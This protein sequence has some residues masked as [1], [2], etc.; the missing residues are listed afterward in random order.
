[1][2]TIP[3]YHATIVPS[4]TGAMSTEYFENFLNTTMNSTSGELI[5]IMN[6]GKLVLSWREGITVLPPAP[7]QDLLFTVDASISTSLTADLDAAASYS[8]VVDWGDGSAD[9]ILSGTGNTSTSHTFTSTGVY[10]VKVSGSSVPRFR[11]RDQLNVV[12]LESLGNVGLQTTDTMFRDCTNLASVNI[13]NNVTSIGSQT[14]LG[15]TSLT[16]ITIPDSVTS[17]GNTTFNGCTSLTSIIIGNSVASIGIDVFDGTNLTY[18]SVDGVD[19]LFSDSYAF[20]IDGFSA[21]GNL[22][23]PSDVGGK[24]VRVI[25]GGAFKNCTSLTSVTIPDS[26]TS[27]GGYAFYNCT[28]LTSV[29]IP[30]S[31]TLIESSVFTLCQSLTSITIPN[32]VTSI[33]INA[34]NNCSSLTSA[35]IGNSVTSIGSYA[36]KNCTSLTSVT[37]PDSVTSIGSSAFAYCNSLLSIAIPDSVTSI[38]SLAFQVCAGLT[39]VTIG[40]SVTSIGN[41]AFRNCTLLATVDLSLPKSVIDAATDIFLSTASPLTLNVPTGTAGWVDNPGQSIGGN[42]NVTVNLV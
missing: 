22:S 40:N 21:T 42:T 17:I 2:A 12:S 23:L 7:E 4:V 5:T 41:Y 26:V 1:M 6:H 8:G 31:I 32:S 18:S 39:S 33:G 34:F 35:T 38:G 27:I 25:A 20:L 29:N 37:I 11:L 3:I 15:C 24:P 16:S 28:S 19:Y 10:Q 14:F 36:F 13:G 9:T 30:N